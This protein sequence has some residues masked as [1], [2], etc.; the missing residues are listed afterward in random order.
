MER[1]MDQYKRK[2][3]KKG[4][5]VHVA[6]IGA[7][8]SGL[9]AA[10]A[11]ARAG[12]SVTIL[13]QKEKV[14]KKILATGNGHCNFT[15]DRM[16]ISCYH[17]NDFAI[18]MIEKFSVRETI[19]FF[20]ELG[21]FPHERNGYYY[22]ASEQASAVVK[23]LVQETERLGVRIMTDTRVTSVQKREGK[24]E[25]RGCFS[26]YYEKTI[27]DHVKEVVRKNGKKKQTAGEIRI[28]EGCCT[29]DRVILAGGGMAS[30][31]LGSDGSCYALARK[32]GHRVIA[33]L[34]ALTGIQCEEEWFK[35]LAGI[36][37]S[38]KVTLLVD[39][40]E[41]AS[42]VGEL[43]LTDYG[44]SG[45]PVFQVSRYAARALAEKKKAEARLLFYPEISDEELERYLETHEEEQYCG[46]F[47]EKL[48]QVLMEQSRMIQLSQRMKRELLCTCKE[49]NGFDRAQVTCGGIA[50]GEVDR[51][52]ME[53]LR[54]SGLYL[55]GEVLDVDGICGGYN[56]QWAW[57]SGWAAGR[58][59]AGDFLQQM[60]IKAGYE[61]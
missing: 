21:I 60:R 29:A 34:P 5:S 40:K 4:L 43:Q 9:M 24:K 16:D 23:L 53:S 13:E 61:F 42:D 3:G 48:L 26:I 49:V 12:A 1:T 41:T 20:R 46:L 59:A 47:P 32:L 17:G 57:S 56:L 54:C 55:A 14:G 28:E 19:A 33:P 2:S 35:K 44:I 39:G 51:E 8:A 58:S 45:I 22:P 52:T 38:A 31:N 15:N 27:R 7:G 10:I 11:A 36:R 37:V 25:E 6:V 50:V 18:H 30:P